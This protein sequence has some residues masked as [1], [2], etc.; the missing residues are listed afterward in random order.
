ML[1]T[2]FDVCTGPRNKDCTVLNA[3]ILGGGNLNVDVKVKQNCNPSKA[4]ILVI[5]NGKELVR[6]QMN[7]PCDH[8]FL[9]PLLESLFTVTKNCVI[10]KWTSSG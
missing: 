2:K 3:T 6:L 5:S 9:R 10:L 1:I 7:K 4:K 8:L